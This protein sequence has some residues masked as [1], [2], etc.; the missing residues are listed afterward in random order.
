MTAA[1]N[2]FLDAPRRWLPL[3]LMGGIYILIGLIFIQYDEPGWGR[4]FVRPWL[5]ILV[6]I[7][8]IATS[9]TSRLSVVC[10]MGLAF[11]ASERLVARLVAWANGDGGLLLPTYILPILLANW[12]IARLPPGTPPKV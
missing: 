11:L 8:S 4:S 12:L 5:W 2:P 9:T 1:P 10:L 3:A 6:G 7:G